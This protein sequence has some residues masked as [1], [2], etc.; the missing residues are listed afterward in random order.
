LNNS[1]SNSSLHHLPTGN[2][3]QLL[4][5]RHG[6]FVVV[7]AGDH[8]VVPLA[9][10]L[11]APINEVAIGTGCSLEMDANGIGTFGGVRLQIAYRVRPVEKAGDAAFLK[12]NKH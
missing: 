4:R 9:A 2:D 12:E 3:N 8:F 7:V 5:R 11:M 6:Q 1:N 10:A